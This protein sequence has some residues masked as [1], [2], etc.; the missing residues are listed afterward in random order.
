MTSRR[1]DPGA[2]RWALARSD[3]P[4]RA[5][6]VGHTLALH[7]DSQGETF[8]GVR[9][10]ADE[11]NQAKKT[12]ERCLAELVEV[13]YLREDAH[14]RGRRRRRY[15][16]VPSGLPQEGDTPPGGSGLPQEGDTP[17]NRV[18]YFGG[19]SGLLSD[20]SGLPQEGD[21]SPDLLISAGRQPTD[22]D[23]RPYAERKARTRSDGR[24]G[25]AGFRRLV[26][27]ILAEDRDEHTAKWRA[28]ITAR[29]IEACRLCD[30]R[31]LRYYLPNGTPT[32]P[33]DPLQSSSDRCDHE[34]EA[35]ADA[36]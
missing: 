36:S 15:A 17:G 11:T 26:D 14:E 12:V 16:V 10:L 28:D 3:L 21:R 30:D 8:A 25:P 4:P 24:G 27:K 2:W 33:D 31:G 19:R 22:D 5:L 20:E 18:G 34:P 1:S 6:L 9:A 23:L 7:M 32:G 13:G 29:A 35:I